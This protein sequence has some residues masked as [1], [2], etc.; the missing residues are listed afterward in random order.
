MHGAAPAHAPRGGEALARLPET[1][2]SWSRGWM[3]ALAGILEASAPKPGNV[4][5]GAAFDDLCYDE[6]VA[7]ALAIAPAMDRATARPL[8]R[9][10]LD[11]VAATRRVVRSNANL[12]IVLAL[13]PL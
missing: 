5:P 12:G 9:T 8:G 4:H 1:L 2:P 11:A 3:A 6:L 7:A 10:I 13:A